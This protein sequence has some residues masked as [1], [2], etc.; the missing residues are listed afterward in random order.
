MLGDGIGV[1]G[2]KGEGDNGEGE[3]LLVLRWLLSLPLL[4]SPLSP[5]FNS[6]IVQKRCSHYLAVSSLRVY[7][8][9]GHIFY[10][11]SEQLVS[12][13]SPEM[14]RNPLRHAVS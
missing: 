9:G 5:S 3:A 4:S 8:R 2:E 11:P 12:V 1:K 10:L 7:Q 13:I 6:V 14:L